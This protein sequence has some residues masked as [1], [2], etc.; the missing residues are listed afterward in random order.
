MVGSRLITRL[1]AVVRWCSIRITVTIRFF[2]HDLWLLRLDDFSQWTARRIQDLR[3]VVLMMRTFSKQ[4]IGYQVTALA[5]RS[6]LAVIPAVAIALYLTDTIGLREKFADLLYQNFGE[7]DIIQTILGAADRIADT[8]ESGLFGFISMASFVWIVLSLMISVRQVFNNV[9]KIERE[10]SVMRMVVG[11]MG[12]VILS[13]FVV[14]I[15]FTGSILYSH[16]LEW[17]LP[18]DFVLAKP[19]KGLMSWSMLAGAIVLVLSAVYKYIPGTYVRYRHALKAALFAGIIFT[20]IQFLY[21]ETQVMVSK[22]SA[23]YGALAAIP[24]F[25][26]WLEMGWSIILYGATLSY[27]FQNVGKVKV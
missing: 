26:I 12:I 19:L 2:T 27:A 22:Q 11:I 1:K 17:I 20:G 8:A 18:A 15:F 10:R 3:T 21:L 6:M 16:I 23:V 7:E 25:M 13:P 9:W 4:K 24:L 5:F 14:M